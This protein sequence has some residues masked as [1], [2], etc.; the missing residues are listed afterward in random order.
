MLILVHG[1]DY[2]RASEKAK[3]LAG[4]KAEIFDFGTGFDFSFLKDAL[5]TSGLFDKQKIL[6]LRDFFSDPS[7]KEEFL[8][9]ADEISHK[10]DLVVFLE[11]QIVRGEVLSFFKKKGKVFVFNPLKESELEKWVKDRLQELNF[12]IEE[13]ALSDLI[14]SVGRDLWRLDLELQKLAAFGFASKKIKPEDVSLLVKESFSADI[15]KTIDAVANRDKKSALKLL[16]KHL[17]KGDSP[18]YIFS[19]FH[20]QFRNLIV[21]KEL[22]KKPLPELIKSLDIY[23]F[24]IRKTYYLCKKFE[25][26]KLKKIYTKLFKLDLAVKKGKIKPELALELL[27]A[28]I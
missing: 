8:K 16:H 2:Y 9:R 28:D 24:V 4:P 19:M 25:M 11:D 7:F 3:E 13:K 26:E 27:I 23:P 1:K 12:S 21:V 20:Y 10:N 22:D 17:E 15:F 18:F 14:A 5:G 6:I